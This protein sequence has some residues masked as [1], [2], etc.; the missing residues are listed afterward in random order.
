MDPNLYEK[1]G[2]LQLQTEKQD[3]A[4]TYLLRLTAGLVDGSIDRARV[5]VNLT[6]RTWNL[7]PEGQRPATPAT[8]NGLPHVVVAPIEDEDDTPLAHPRPE[9]EEEAIPF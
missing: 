3:E 8:I 1:I 5:L 4:Y 9:P 6:D 7:A 2:R